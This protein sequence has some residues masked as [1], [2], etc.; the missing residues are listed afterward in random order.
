MKTILY[1]ILEQFADWELAYLSSAVNM[2]GEGK[3]ENKIVSLT[4]N[5]VTSIGGVKCLPDCDLQD[6]PKDYDALILIGGLSWH[7]EKAIELKPLIETCLKDGNVLGAI[8]D[9]C[10]FLGSVG[11]LNKVMHTANSLAELQ[12]HAAYTNAQDFI[13]RQ[14]VADNKV[15]TANGTAPF[16]S[17]QQVLT[18]LSA[19]SEEK[20]IRW[21][22]FHTLSF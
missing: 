18:V 13:P 3:F 21:N 20:I 22:D 15:A 7:D 12:Q 16:V 1:V 8:C 6:I 9:A 2:L 14:A 10:R 17:A 11:A 19:A 5:A 4:K